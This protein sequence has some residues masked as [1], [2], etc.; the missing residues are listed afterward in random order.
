MQ[1]SISWRDHSQPNNGIPRPGVI[2]LL[3]RLIMPGWWGWALTRGQSYPA[4]D[5][6]ADAQQCDGTCAAGRHV[7]CLEGIILQVYIVSASKVARSL[8]FG[9]YHLSLTMHEGQFAF[10]TFT[11]TYS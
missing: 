7:L 11:G 6:Q 8:H 5:Y 10:T 9:S 3:Q 2:G 1:G 4:E